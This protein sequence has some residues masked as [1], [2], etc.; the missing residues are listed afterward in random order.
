MAF[1]ELRSTWARQGLLIPPTV[2][3]AGFIGQLTLEV[4]AMRD[5]PTPYG[6][7]FAH[8]IFAQLLRPTS[9]YCGKYQ[10]QSGI[11]PAISDQE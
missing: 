6:Q 3:D 1:V 11:T 9:P 8:L 2:V 7:R 10:G 4:V 5:I